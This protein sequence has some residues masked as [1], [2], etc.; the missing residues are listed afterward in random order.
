MGRERG[1]GGRRQGRKKE[2]VKGILGGSVAAVDT[3]L[4]AKRGWG[5]GGGSG[6][7]NCEATHVTSAQAKELFYL[8]KKKQNQLER[9]QDASRFL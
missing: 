1:G 6:T 7:R 8:K 9:F 4:A 3:G 5:E 2:I